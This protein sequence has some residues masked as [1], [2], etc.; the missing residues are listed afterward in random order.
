MLLGKIKCYDEAEGRG[1]IEHDKGK[2][3]PFSKS[4]IKDDADK[5]LKKGQAVRFKIT[6]GREGPEAFDV[7]PQQ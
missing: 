1:C 6:L 2:D 3:L 7:V 5:P 4:Q